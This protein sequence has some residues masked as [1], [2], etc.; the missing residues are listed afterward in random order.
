[1]R[2]LPTRST[3]SD[4]DIDQGGSPVFQPHAISHPAAIPRTSDA[5][6][7]IERSPASHRREVRIAA[8]TLVLAAMVFASLIAPRLTGTDTVV[9]V[10]IFAILFAPVVA[11]SVPAWVRGVAGRV[12]QGAALPVAA[13]WGV[14]LAM[15]ALHADASGVSSARPIGALAMTAG[16]TLALTASRQVTLR[17]EAHPLRLLLAILALWLTT[18]LGMLHGLGFPPGMPDGLDAGRLLMLDLGLALFLVVAP[19][20]DVGYS[21]SFRFTDLL[22]AAVALS[23]FATIAIPLGL[24]TGFI[25]WSGEMPTPL[26]ALTRALGIFFLVAIPEELLFRGALQNLLERHWP[27]AGAARGSLVLASI[28]FG[29]AHLD[30]PPTPNIRYALLATLAGVAYGWVWQRTRRV[31]AAALTHAAVDW[32]WV[33]MF[34]N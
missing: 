21:F 15:V 13:A 5:D 7:V 10:A 32:I 12:A 22:A 11:L 19:L 34:G 26:T 29:I 17:P 4:H 18:E 28:L 30:N 24:A 16:V 3:R 33:T 6:V 23:A 2:A 1:M 8:G 9:S 31:T 20:P 27:F 14:M 25:A